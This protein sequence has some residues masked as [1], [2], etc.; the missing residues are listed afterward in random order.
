M[1]TTDGFCKSMKLYRYIK[2]P[3]VRL[4][5][6]TPENLLILFASFH[7]DIFEC[8]RIVAVFIAKIGLMYICSSE[9]RHVGFE[10]IESSR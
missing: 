5:A 10:D 6:T 4:K 3:Q 9:C 2:T 8:F 7:P 1:A